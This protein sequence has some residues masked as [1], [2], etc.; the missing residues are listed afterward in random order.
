MA[1]KFSYDWTRFVLRIEIAAPAQRVFRAWTHAAD[2]SAWFAEKAESEPEKGG[3][4]Y[5]EFI[6]GDK[7]DLRFVQLRKPGLVSFTFGP[8]VDLVTVRIKS[9]KN[10]CICELEQTGM[11][12]G[13]KDRVHTHMGC[14]TGW[15]FFLTSLKAYLEHGIDLRSHNPRRTYNQSY[16]NS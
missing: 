10:G 8:A 3:R 6:G 5:L 11:K 7:A 2:L 13:P 4:L 9:I 12:T 1:E 16:V 15:V 14:K